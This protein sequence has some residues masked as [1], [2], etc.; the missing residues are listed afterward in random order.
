LLSMGSFVGGK[1]GEEMC[2]RTFRKNKEGKGN[3]SNIL[4][5]EE[6]RER[7]SF[8]SSSFSLSSGAGERGGK[9]RE[10]EGNLSRYMG[11][12]GMEGA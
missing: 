7:S 10:K 6:R 11:K 2:Q 9:K 3:V 8:Y 4:S 12:K 5:L 1:R